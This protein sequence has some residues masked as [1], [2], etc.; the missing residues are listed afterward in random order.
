MPTCKFVKPTDINCL[1]RAMK[2]EA[3]CFSHSQREEIVSKRKAAQSLGG[4]NSRRV[5]NPSKNKIK[6]NNMCDVVSAIENT[7][8]DIKAGNIST[9]VANSMGYLLNIAVKAL[10]QRDWEARIIK[11]EEAAIKYESEKPNPKT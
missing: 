4:K 1:A 7:I 11:L 2:N 10:E 9:N 6:L 3:Y 8:N 5:H